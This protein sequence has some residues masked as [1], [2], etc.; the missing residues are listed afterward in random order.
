M[1]MI[2][3]ARRIGASEHYEIAERLGSATFRVV[4]YTVVEPPALAD[5]SATR[6]GGWALDLYGAQGNALVRGIGVTPW[7]ELL[8]PY[9]HLAVPTGSLV[10]DTLDGL[11]PDLTAFA[12]GRARLLYK[13]A[14]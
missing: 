2:R 9:R 1:S 10:C 13:D 3:I 8:Y 14:S 11:D 6:T 12:E 4:L 7:I 5:F